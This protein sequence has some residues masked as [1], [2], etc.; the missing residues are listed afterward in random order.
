MN[1]FMYKFAYRLPL[2][3]HGL[4]NRSSG[5]QRSKPSAIRTLLIPGTYIAHRAIANLMS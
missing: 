5:P 3:S 2:Q 1:T 4:Q